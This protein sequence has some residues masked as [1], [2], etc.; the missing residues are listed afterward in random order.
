MLMLTMISLLNLL[1]T[2]LEYPALKR[3][4]CLLN[5]S[6]NEFSYIVG[7]EYVHYFDLSSLTIDAALREFLRKLVLTGETQERERILAHF[8][9][10]YLECNPGTFNS[11]GNI[12][13]SKLMQI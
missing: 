10:R 3:V 8:S 12:L 1:P 6:R 13:L 9:H 4:C 7:V 2:L 5:C 11:E